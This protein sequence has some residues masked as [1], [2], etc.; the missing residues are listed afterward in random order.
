MLSNFSIYKD[1]RKNGIKLETTQWSQLYK[2]RCYL[3][4]PNSS[5]NIYRENGQ[6]SGPTLNIVSVLTW[7]NTISVLK[8]HIF[9]DTLYVVVMSSVFT[10]HFWPI[11]HVFW[12]TT[13]LWDVFRKNIHGMQ[14]S[15]FPKNYILYD[16]NSCI[17][18]I[19]GTSTQQKT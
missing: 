15:S 7:G 14:C 5:T 1:L 16:E 17:M 13:L 10:F 12:S 3:F 19:T 4:Q 2:N 9:C 8:I 11:M 6:S 18:L